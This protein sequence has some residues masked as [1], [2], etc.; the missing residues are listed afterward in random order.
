MSIISKYLITE[1]CRYVLLVLTVVVAIYVAVDFFERIDNFIESGVP[2]PRAVV[3]FTFKIPFIIAQILP[4]CVLLSVLIVF[5]LMAKN[6]EILALKSSGVSIWQLLK[7]VLLVGIAFSIFLF[8]FSEAVV[9]ITSGKAN[10]IWLREVR[11]RSAVISKE[12]NVWLRDTRLITYIKFYDKT[13]ETIYG[14]TL[15]YFDKDFRLVRRLDAK[16]GVF[17]GGKWLLYE[18]M[19]QKLDK[20][21]GN[22]DIT[23]RKQ[24]PES[25]SLAPE[26]LTTVIK[27]SEEMNFKELLEYARKIES[28]GYDATPYRVDLHAKTAFPFVC[29]ILCLAGAGIA[30]KRKTKDGMATGIA[31]GIGI[32]F[33]YWIFHSF[34]ISLGYG[35]RLPPPIAAWSANLLFLCFGIINMLKTE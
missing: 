4:V 24:G 31:Y 17:R 7:P 33:L 9:P 18:I 32:A 35:E 28:E 1:I 29:F 13:D 27:K 30:L 8:F 22:Y 2:F 34:C 11:G 23:I 10:N 20:A 6:N 21:T 16:K 19:D 5:G 12:K 3:Y 25:L 15:H 26:N 14:L